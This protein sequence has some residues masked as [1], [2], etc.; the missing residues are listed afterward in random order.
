MKLR[1]INK[2]IEKERNDI[3]PKVGFRLLAAT[4][5]TKLFWSAYSNIPIS[6]DII[7]KTILMPFMKT[8]RIRVLCDISFTQ[9]VAFKICLENEK[10]ICEV[11]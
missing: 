6:D 4:R 11:Y 9:C 10:N 2:S 8:K 1:N 7:M 5:K 3:L